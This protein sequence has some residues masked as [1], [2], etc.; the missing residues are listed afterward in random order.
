MII[1]KLELTITRA[2]VD[3]GILFS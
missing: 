2:I 1:L 3:K